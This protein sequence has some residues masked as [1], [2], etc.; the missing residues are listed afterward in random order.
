M[1]DKMAVLMEFL[2][3]ELL[4]FYRVASSVAW[5]EPIWAALTVWHKV[6]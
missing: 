3:V 4:V 5:R 6:P 1:V 2:K